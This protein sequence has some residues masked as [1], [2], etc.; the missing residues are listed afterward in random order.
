[1]VI[2]PDK[3]P[4]LGLHTPWDHT[5]DPFSSLHRMLN[6][7]HLPPPL[8][9]RLVNALGAQQAKYELRWM[10]QSLQLYPH[11]SNPKVDLEDMI[12]RRV[13]GEPLQYILG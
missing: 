11:S 2:T 8:F 7:I 3:P 9:S 5:R 13:R 12:H 1:M 4:S 6:S 10:R